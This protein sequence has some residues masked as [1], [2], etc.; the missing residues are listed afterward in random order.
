MVFLSSVQI[1][2]AQVTVQETCVEMLWG[3][4]WSEKNA[5]KI[6][7]NYPFKNPLSHRFQATF[8]A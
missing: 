5:G 3:A 8:K 1:I 7:S 2:G 6:Y 4:G